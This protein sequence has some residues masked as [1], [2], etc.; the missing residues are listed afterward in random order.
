M[1]MLS[2]K[3][4]ESRVVLSNKTSPYHLNLTLSNYLAGVHH[5]IGNIYQVRLSTVKYQVLFTVFK[6][7]KQR[8]QCIKYK[9]SY[10]TEHSQISVNMKSQDFCDTLPLS[11]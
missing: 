5:N 9:I 8:T 3:N 4:P 7:Y 11:I 6:I 2:N 10:K 1:T